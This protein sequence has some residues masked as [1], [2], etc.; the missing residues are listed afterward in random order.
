MINFH[1]LSKKFC[2]KRKDETVVAITKNEYGFG[3]NVLQ[4]L[5]MSWNVVS[6]KWLN[7]IR[8]ISCLFGSFNIK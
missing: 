7:A 3:V 4:R 2:L 5:I 1:I 8:W 6:D